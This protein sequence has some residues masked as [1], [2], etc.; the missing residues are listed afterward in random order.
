MSISRT[1]PRAQGIT[2]V[3]STARTPTSSQMA[4]SSAFTPVVSAAAGRPAP[5]LAGRVEVGAVHAEHELCTGR[6]GIADLP[7]VERV[8]AHPHPGG[9]EL[10]HHG[11]EIGIR[12]PGGAADIDDVRPAGAVVLGL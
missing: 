9:D 5:G 8:D 3:V 11:A 6:H 2:S 12:E 1:A 7:R 4:T 10:A